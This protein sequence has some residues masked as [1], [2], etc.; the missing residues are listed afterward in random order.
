VKVH[1][2]TGKWRVEPGIIPAAEWEKI[3]RRVALETHD[4]IMAMSGGQGNEDPHVGYDFSK[5]WRT[6]P[7]PQGV[8]F[9]SMY[10]Y[11]GVVAR[12]AQRLWFQHA[13]QIAHDFIAEKIAGLDPAERESVPFYTQSFGVWDNGVKTS[14]AARMEGPHVDVG[15]TAEF[16]VF[17]EKWEFGK[18]EG[19]IPRVIPYQYIG[20]MNYITRELQA[21]F[22]G[23]HTIFMTPVKPED[24][25][26]ITAL[27][28]PKARKTPVMLVP[29]IRVRPVQYQKGRRR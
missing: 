12:E 18:R 6:S 20:V 22:G 19:Q 16:A 25:S 28:G 21:S 2:A 1:I 15:P 7:L 23:N 5:N 17:L 29:I 9:G 11:W 13:P 8:V 3:K 27:D 4:K 10:D 24:R 14:F 26:A